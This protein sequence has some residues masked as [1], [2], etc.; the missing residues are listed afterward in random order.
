MRHAAIGMALVTAEGRFLEVNAALC[1]MFGRE[2]AELRQLL[3][4]DLTHA[5]DLAESQQL[6]EEIVS[7]RRDAFQC[8]KRYWRADGELIWGQVSVS[9]LR[10]GETCLFIV[11]IVDVSETRRQRQALAEQ[12]HQVRRLE[13]NAAD[14]VVRLEEALQTDPL[15]GLTSRGTMLRRIDA[16]L[17]RPDRRGCAAVLSIGIDRLSQVNHALTHRAGDL[18]ISCVAERLVEALEQPE[19][20]ARGTGD[21]FIVLL[22]SLETAQLASATAERLRLAVKG[23]ISYAGHAIEPSVSIG[24]AIAPPPQPAP[25]DRT[26]PDLDPATATA[27]ELLRDA[28]LAMR[29]AASLGRDRCAI[30]DPRLAERAQQRL[31]LQEELR[32]ALQHGELQTWLMPVVALNG[33]QL[34]GYEALVRWPRPDGRLAM[35]DTFLPVARSCGLAEAIDLLVLRQ[36]IDALAQLPDELSVA[37]NLSAD[38]LGQSDLVDRLSGWLSEA[39]VA[40]ERL[41][42]EITETALLSLAPQVITTIQRLAALGVR[43]LV[44]DFGTGFSSISHLRDLP[45]HGL[46]LDRSFSEGLRRGD[47]KSVRLAQALGGLAEGLGLDTVAEGIETAEQAASL[48]D[49]GWRC[50]QGWHFGQAAP[51]SHWQDPAGAAGGPLPAAPSAPAPQS[52]GPEALRIP[53]SRSSWALAVTDNVPVGLFALRLPPAG[54]PE[55]LFV[56]RR[57]LEMMQLEREQLMADPELL[58]SRLNRR[59][60]RALIRLWRR[61]ARLDTPLSWEGRLWMGSGEAE[62]DGSWVHLEASPLRQ[63]DGSRVWQGVMSDIT[64]RKRQQLHLQRLLDEAPIAMA[65]NDLRDNDPRITYINQQFIRSFGYNL[66]TIPRLSDWARL[67][68]PDPQQ[69]QTVFEAWEAGVMRARHGDGVVEPIEAKVTTAD[70][71]VRDALFS[72]VLLG[73]ELVI[74]VLDITDWRQAER[75]LQTAR[76][77]L[78]DTAL[79]ITEAIPVGTYT[80]RLP[81]EGGMASFVFMSERFLEICGLQRQEAAADPFKA[82]AC[83]HPDDYDAWVQINAEA[84]ANKTPFYGECRIVVD[85]ELR[86]ISAESVPRTLEDGSTVWEGVLIDITQQRMTLAKL[87]QERAL[88]ETVLSHID[89]H[90]YMKDRQGRYLYANRGV[91]RLLNRSLASILGRNDAELL[92][93]ATAEAIQRVDAQVVREGGPLWVEE[94][95][96]QTD[97]SERIFLS[98]KL[99]YR[100]PGQEECMIGFSTDI[101][102]LRQAS[103]QLAASEEHFRLLAEN[104]SDV[105]FRLA[106]DGRILWV[107]PSL[108]NALGWRPEEWLGKVG[109]DFLVHR[110]EA[111]HYRHNLHTLQHGGGTTLARDQVRARDGSIHWIETHAGPY[112]DADGTIDGVV[113]SFRLI[114]DIVAAEQRLLQ[115]EQRQRR[116]ADTILDVVWSIDLKGQFTYMSPSVQR[117]RGFTPEEVMAMPLEANFTPASFRIVAAGLEQ[118]NRDVAAGQP[119]RFQAELEEICKDGSTVWTDVRAT[120]LHNE[121]GECLEIVG[122]S[123]DITAQHQLREELRIS[124]ERYRLLAENARDVIWTMQPDGQISYVSPS[125]Q[126]LRGFSAEEAMA[127]PLEQIHPQDSLQ[128]SSAYFQQLREDIAAGREPQSFR[129][130]LEYLCRDGTTIWTEVLALPVLDAQGRFRQLL[131]VSRDISER[132]RFERQLLQANQQLEQLAISDG[133]TGISNRRHMES[134]IQQEISRSDRYGEPLSLILC[135]L[136]HFKRINDHFGHGCGD[137]VLIEFCR[138]IQQQLRSSDSFGRWGGE[139]F[140]ILLPCSDAAAAAAL[141]DK[142]R[143]RLTATPIEP[144]GLVTCSFGVAQRRPDEAVGEWLQRVDNRLYAAKAGGR[145]RVV[146]A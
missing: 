75:D 119:I 111:E 58:V 57:W 15:T 53:A 120:G 50:G 110:G 18:L 138:R 21:T 11:Q 72:A 127:Q 128:R 106:N 135:D 103:Q 107:S 30:A 51:L 8:E 96:P 37:A 76:S 28:T 133:L 108:T 70:G 29:E 3:L 112:R 49:L 65:I 88:L 36:T 82:F 17:K 140:L 124:E 22:D 73:E 85:G 46:K 40:P 43:W 6:V 59:D 104:S 143:Q 121:Q 99:L 89:A 126:L 93:A 27:D 139:E 54:D 114:D 66:C 101:T 83:V 77:A 35:P 118:A 123:R 60:R 125:I 64:E 19:Q 69:R 146:E 45:I 56:S 81:P 44:D 71:C 5:D 31:A 16:H 134:L 68:Y 78:A 61:H 26:A 1:R 105:V 47:Q 80:M 97:G 13:E 122:V 38:S 130:E 41:H 131:G 113:A 137:Q 87:E 142:L 67:A 91:E 129:G 33:G 55:V 14:A 94:R 34:Q 62:G 2:E 48:R 136:D 9:C 115:S 12:Q 25:T 92:P 20:A 116:L 86:W 42:L 90:V 39:G 7:G 79:A 10:Q 117:L 74:S 95:V 4:R 141:A 102:Q 132:K 23:T 32:H 98:K 144:V 109:T 24:V 52:A 100:P 84:F 63:A 145:N